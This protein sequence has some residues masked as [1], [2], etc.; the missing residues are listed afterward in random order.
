[1]GRHT[2]SGSSRP[3]I[4][5]GLRHR[6]VAG[7]GALSLIG[8]LSLTAAGPATGATVGVPN[9]SGNWAGY[10]ATGS[11]ITSVTGSWTVPSAGTVPPGLSATWVGIGGYKTSDLI[12]AGTPA[13]Q[14]PV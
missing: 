9:I 4:G 5:H 10:V 3:A 12:Q 8:G 2:A 11:S 14:R 7:L 1:M 6:L 13:G